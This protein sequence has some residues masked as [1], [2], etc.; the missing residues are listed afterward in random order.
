MTQSCFSSNH[1]LSSMNGF[2]PRLCYGD[3]LLSFVWS[4]NVVDSKKTK[5]VL[6]FKHSLTYIIFF[7]PI[8]FRVKDEEP[9]PG[10]HQHNFLRTHFSR[11]THCDYCGKKIWL[12]EAAQ[13]KKCSM[14]CHKKCIKKCQLSTVCTIAQ[15]D[16][17]SSPNATLPSGMVTP[18]VSLK[19]VD[20][21]KSDNIVEDSEVQT[22]IGMF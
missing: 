3:A 18:S 1:P 4:G 19:I 14:S 17:N 11:A 21:D 15:S 7:I 13:C 9:I 20:T 5:F 12:K 6:F 10:T 16:A 2:E 8:N 22:L